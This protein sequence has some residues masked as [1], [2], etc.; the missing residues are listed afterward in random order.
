[1][2][3]VKTFARHKNIYVASPKNGYS[4]A[5]QICNFIANRSLNYPGVVSDLVL[6]VSNNV[7]SANNLVYWNVK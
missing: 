5:I 4:V 7:Q 1:M 6:L 2:Q 3:H